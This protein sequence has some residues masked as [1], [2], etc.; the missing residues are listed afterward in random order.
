M[1]KTIPCSG[2]GTPVSIPAKYARASRATCLKCTDT[3][4]NSL[5]E[6]FKAGWYADHL[7]DLEQQDEQET[8]EFTEE[9]AEELNRMFADGWMGRRKP[10]KE[11]PREK[12]LVKMWND[13]LESPYIFII[14]WVPQVL[15]GGALVWAT[16]S[17]VYKETTR[18]TMA[19]YT[20]FD[21]CV[22]NIGSYNACLDLQWKRALGDR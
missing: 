4:P 15:V 13:S 9:E 6:V 18:P 22:N 20:N 5:G 17:T 1:T 21:R 7:K 10:A 11:Q 16:G 14:T 8:D 19:P 2:C 3:R 12:F